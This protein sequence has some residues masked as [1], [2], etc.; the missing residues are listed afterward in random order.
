MKFRK[1]FVSEYEEELQE[2][3]EQSELREKYDVDDDKTVKIVK[4]SA[5]QFTIATVKEILRIIVAVIFLIFFGIGVLAIIY[6]GPR[7][8]MLIL[9]QKILN[10]LELYLPDFLVFWN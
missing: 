6:P 8:E 3:A 5:A 9:F 4:P 2:Q 1:G 7:S 10:E